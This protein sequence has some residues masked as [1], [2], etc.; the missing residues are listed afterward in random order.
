VVSLAFSYINSANKIPDHFCLVKISGI[1]T[2]LHFWKA[3]SIRHIVCEFDVCKPYNA[4]VVTALVRG[5][6]A[7]TAKT[8]PSVILWCIVPC[9]PCVVHWA[10]M[11]SVYMV[12]YN[13]SHSLSPS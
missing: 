4:R 3:F 11:V 5:S 8:Q 6:F 12:E 13:M 1:I 2:V 10:S 9:F 7:K